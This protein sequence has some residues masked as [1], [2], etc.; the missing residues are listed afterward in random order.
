LT[1]GAPG[2]GVS[3]PG[4]IWRIVREIMFHRL[5]ERHFPTGARVDD[6]HVYL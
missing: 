1:I 3:G 2:A 6:L 5:A 4:S